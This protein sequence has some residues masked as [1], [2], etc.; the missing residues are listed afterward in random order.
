M[1]KSQGGRDDFG[2]FFPSNNELN[3]IAFGTHTKTAEPIEIPFGMMIGLGSR[4]RTV[5]CGVTITEVEGKI[6]GKHLPR[7]A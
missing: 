4:N 6:L 7:Q 2:V 3:S 5:W 1:T